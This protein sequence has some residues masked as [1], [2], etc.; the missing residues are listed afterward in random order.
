MVKDSTWTTTYTVAVDY[1]VAVVD[2][3]TIITSVGW[4]SIAAGENV[5]VSGSV[6]VNAGE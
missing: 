3:E 2:N 5:L 6:E 4:G 1:T